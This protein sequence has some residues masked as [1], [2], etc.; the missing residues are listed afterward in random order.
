M[1][2]MSPEAKKAAAAYVREWRRKNPEKAR[3]TQVRYWEKKARQAAETA[4]TEKS[5]GGQA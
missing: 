2:E 3:A 4:A 5:P 1:A